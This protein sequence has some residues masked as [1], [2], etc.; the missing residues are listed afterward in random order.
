M[1]SATIAIAAGHQRLD[2]IAI[3][4]GPNRVFIDCTLVDEAGTK[5]A[6]ASR[7]S[8]SGA[9]NLSDFF[10]DI[11]AQQSRGLHQQHA[12]QNDERDAFGI[13]RALRKISLHQRLGES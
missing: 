3:G 11:L 1:T 9:E 2:P 12:N 8:A 13:L 10:D 5:P 7:S 6:P 4:T